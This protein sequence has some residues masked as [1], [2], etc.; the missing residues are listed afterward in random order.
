MGK[1][2]VPAVGVVAETVTCQPAPEAVLSATVSCSSAAVLS[3]TLW[4]TPVSVA[5]HVKLA[6]EVR[7]STPLRAKAV[8]VP[9]STA[10]LVVLVTISGA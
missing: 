1:A 3:T 9:E 6:G 7:V 2:C 10:A 8:D 5:A 4:L